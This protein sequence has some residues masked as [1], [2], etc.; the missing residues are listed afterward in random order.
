MVL[1]MVAVR[2]SALDAFMRPFFV[3]TTGIAV[4]SFQDEVKNPDS[5]MSK[6]P[7][8]FALF[9]LGTFDE[10]TGKCQNL[11]SPRQLVRGNDLKERVNES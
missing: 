2:D 7:E 1:V 4:R 10:D 9:E 8:D 5:P 6:H 11:A 3:P